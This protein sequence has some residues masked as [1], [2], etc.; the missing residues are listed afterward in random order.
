M[1]F[2]PLWATK[3]VLPRLMDSTAVSSIAH[4]FA[5]S[6]AAAG[7]FTLAASKIPQYSGPGLE[8]WLYCSKQQRAGGR[9]QE[10]KAA[11]GGKGSLVWPRPSRP[12]KTLGP[13]GG[14]SPVPTWA[15]P[16]APRCPAVLSLSH[17][18]RSLLACPPKPTP[19]APSDPA[20]A[21]GRFSPGLVDF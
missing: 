10:G 6:T 16:F 18:R 17:P 2:G 4:P 12:T 11:K 21:E 3:S 8:N 19:G 9:Q 15:R 20:W 13:E 1:H 14:E 5:L 7:D